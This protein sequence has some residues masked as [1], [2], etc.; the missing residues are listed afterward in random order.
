[1]GADHREMLPLGLWVVCSVRED[2]DEVS[3]R[4]VGRRGA[5]VSKSND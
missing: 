3:I 1:M 2:E 5:L 4:G